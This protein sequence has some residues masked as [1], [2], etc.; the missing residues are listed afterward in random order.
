MREMKGHYASG[1]T[2]GTDSVGSV[3]TPSPYLQR[4]AV[5]KGALNGAN[6]AIRLAALLTQSEVA[7]ALGVSRSA[8]QA[9]EE[10]RRLPRGAAAER[11]ATLL[12]E[13]AEA[14]GMLEA[15]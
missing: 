7:E 13:L 9:W 4:S 14:A 2:L 10:G 3:T 12:A 5:R 8:L 6:R 1:L 11:Y 15:R